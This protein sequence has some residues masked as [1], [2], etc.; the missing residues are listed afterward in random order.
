MAGGTAAEDGAPLLIAG[1]EPVGAPLLGVMVARGEVEAVAEG[2]VEAVAEGE[3]EAVAESLGV[4][5]ELADREGLGL[6][7]GSA[8]GVVVG[9]VLADGSGAAEVARLGEV[10]GRGPAEGQHSCSEVVFRGFG[11]SRNR[12]AGLRGDAACSDGGP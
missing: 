12:T 4:G 8:L 9:W 3:T 7:V 6:V 5:D 2:V 10:E 11:V 1:P